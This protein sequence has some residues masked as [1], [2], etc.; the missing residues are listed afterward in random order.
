MS[1]KSAVFLFLVYLTYC[2][3]GFTPHDDN[4]HQI[5]SW[6]DHPLLSYS[7]LAADTL[8]DLDLLSF[9][10][11]HTWWVTCTTPPPSFKIL[12]LS[13]LG[14]WIMT[15]AMT[16]DLQPLCLRQIVWLLHMGMKN[17]YTFGIPIPY[18]PIHRATYIG[19]CWRLGQFAF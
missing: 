5:W 16:M 6:Y 18:L 11:C 8:C 10:N 13:V 15:S 3:T 9:D 7:I 17:N 4:F 2:V 14:L 1:W 12:D 19:L